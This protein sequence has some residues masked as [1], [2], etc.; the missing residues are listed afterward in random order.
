M[1]TLSLLAGL[2]LWGPGLASWGE[3]AEQDELTV[4][5]WNV[6]RLWGD[7]QSAD[8]GCVR[9]VIEREQPDVVALMEVSRENLASL[10]GL[11]LD[12]VHTPY[13]S[14]DGDRRGGVAVCGRQG[15]QASGRGR[16]FVDG[17]DWSYLSAEVRRDERVLNVLAVHLLPQHVGMSASAKERVAA[18]Q[19]DQSRALVE[20]VQRFRDPTVVAGDFNSTRD[21]WLHAALRER[22]WDVWERGGLGFGATKHLWGWLPLRIDFVYVSRSIGVHETRVLPDLCS[23]HQPLASR[24]SLP[25]DPAGEPVRNEP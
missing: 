6:Q 25:T 9:S 21:F 24:L 23:D 22:L 10:D 12:C 20:H 4:L 2:V 19:A 13:T 1:L 3:P 11:G 18:R 7:G 14:R 17:E 8:P 16:R 15:W 5:S